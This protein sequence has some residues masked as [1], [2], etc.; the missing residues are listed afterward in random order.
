MPGTGGHSSGSDVRRVEA[1]NERLQRL[2]SLR[3]RRG[4]VARRFGSVFFDP[5]IWGRS[6][7]IPAPAKP[8]LQMASNAGPGDGGSSIWQ[9]P[10]RRSL[11]PCKSRPVASSSREAHHLS[12]HRWPLGSLQHPCGTTMVCWARKGT[13]RAAEQKRKTVS[14]LKI[15]KTLAPRAFWKSL[16]L[17]IAAACN[18]SNLL[19]SGFRLEIVRPAA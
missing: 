14:L 15:V 12:R 2:P 4:R 19:L 3:S 6:R 17:S 16:N 1:R 10:T 9:S 11:R 7:K 5:A 18:A 13:L 8:T